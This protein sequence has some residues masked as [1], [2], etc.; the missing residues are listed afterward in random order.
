MSR[1]VS[2]APSPH[3]AVIGMQ[4]GDEGKGQIVD[5]ATEQFDYIVR[6]NGGNNAGHTV[7]IGDERYA[8]HLI[9]SGILN[10]ETINVIGNGVVIDPVGLLQEIAG[11]RRR[12]IEV[13]D[14]L[15]ISDRAHLVLPYHKVQDGLMEAA[16]S[17]ARGDGKKIGT[18]GRGIGPAYADKMLRSVALRMADML[19]PDRFRD[20]LRH[21]AAVKNVMLQPIAELA[22]EPFEP[23]DGEKLAEEYLG[24]ADQLR[25]HVCDTTH[26][27]HT[28]MADGKKLLFEGA[29]ACLLDVDHGTY[30]YVTSS[31]CSSGG[32]YPG[33]AV[34]GGT[35]GRMIGVVKMYCS[36]VGGGPFPTELHGETA[37][38]IRDRG[39]EYGTTTGRPRRC[40]WLDL[41]ALRYTTRLCGTTELACTGLSVV[42]GLDALKLCVGYR[43]EGRA[44]PS[45]PA[46]PA[47]LGAVEP[48]YEELPA[49]EQPL[50]D[51]SHYD[52][53]PDA[54]RQ[55]L[56]FIADYVGV[57]VS[58]ACVG[59]KR[60][61]IIRIPNEE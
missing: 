61:Q 21:I 10:D 31:N 46:N 55:Y 27:L 44:L 57:P 20:K 11:L 38:A 17:E 7:Q 19:D 32:I 59:R 51:C 52:D 23:Y 50:E 12:G 24:Y 53:L 37:D 49:I 47:V 58:M 36:R 43:H 14:N 6:Y 26:L 54:A 56:R 39:N 45:F 5:L 40:G 4:W 18:T 33:A 28:A 1:A 30:P 15:R 2:T 35:V 13:G 16:V 34:P 8:L 9:P 3:A 22:G 25:P 42:A 48:I 60:S 29:N 41:F